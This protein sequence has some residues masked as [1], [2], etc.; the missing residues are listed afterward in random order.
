MGCTVTKGSVSKKEAAATAVGTDADSDIVDNEPSTPVPVYVGTGVSRFSKENRSVL[1]VFGGP[2]S[3]KGLLIEE[4]VHEFEFTSINVEDIVFNYLPNKVAN[5]VENIVEIQEL[6][7]RDPSVLT[8]EWVMNLI[9][10][11]LSTSMSQ[12]FVIDIVPALN[13]ILK[14]DSFQKNEHDKELEMFERR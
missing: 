11:K 4:L 7:K 2:G 5:T 1:F 6:L 12:R 10:A 3:Q 13:T 8:V 9:S 14:S